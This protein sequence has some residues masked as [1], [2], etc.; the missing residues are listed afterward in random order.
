MR[1]PDE[2]D[3]WYNQTAPLSLVGVEEPNWQVFVLMLK[4]F[5]DEGADSDLCADRT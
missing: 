5:R 3:P 4:G 1:R 2:M